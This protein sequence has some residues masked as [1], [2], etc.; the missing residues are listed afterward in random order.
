M[1]NEISASEE[2]PSFDS[3]IMQGHAELNTSLMLSNKDSIHQET[4]EIEKNTINYVRQMAHY[5]ES[6]NEL[7]PIKIVG[8]RA[9][10]KMFQGF[11]AVVVGFLATAIELIGLETILGT[12]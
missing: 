2:L 1:A 12:G 7:N 11:I 3:Q 6:D 5:L 9:D 4:V 10:W 8:V